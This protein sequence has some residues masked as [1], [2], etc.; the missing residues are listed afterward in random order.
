MRNESEIMNVFHEDSHQEFLTAQCEIQGIRET[1][2]CV[3][4]VIQDLVRTDFNELNI[5]TCLKPTFLLFLRDKITQ[6]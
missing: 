6:Q 1:L 2:S 4:E 5:S 3:F